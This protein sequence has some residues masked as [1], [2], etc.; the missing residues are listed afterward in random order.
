ME[1]NSFDPVKAE[2]MTIDANDVLPMASFA[3]AMY[4]ACRNVG[5]PDGRAFA[6]S[7]ACTVQMIAVMGGVKRNEDNA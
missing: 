5:F 4:D 7:K 3:K 6:L 1:N 2:F